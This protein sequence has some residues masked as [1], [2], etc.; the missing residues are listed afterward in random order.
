M[1]KQEATLRRKRRIRAKITGTS[2]RPRLAVHLSLT[3][4]RAQLIDD[5]TGATLASA[6]E[7]RADTG[8]KTERAARVGERLAVA[9]KAAGITT[10][11]FDR[12]GHPFRGRTRAVADA[13]RNAGLEF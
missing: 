8:T 9:A 3:Q 1:S 4:T 12:A 11:V 2:G 10:V 7:D 13:A 5:E 6:R